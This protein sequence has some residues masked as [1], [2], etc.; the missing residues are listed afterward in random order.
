MSEITAD[1]PHREY[2]PAYQL[3]YWRG[4]SACA[5]SDAEFTHLEQQTPGYGN[6]TIVE[7]FLRHPQNVVLLDKLRYALETAFAA[8]Q[9]AKAE[10][11]RKALGV[12]S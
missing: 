7:L 9:A 5:R 6:R 12:A 10:E 11:L 8:G 2:F 3:S 1:N 4:G